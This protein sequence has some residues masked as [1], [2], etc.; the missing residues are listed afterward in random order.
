MS[1]S[2]GQSEGIDLAAVRA[3]T[4]GV[5]EVVHL[6]NAGAALPPTPVVQAVQAHI[7]LEARIGGYE[8]EERRHAQ[9]DRVYGAAAELLHCEPEEIAFIE[10]ATWAWGHGVL[11]V[12]ARAR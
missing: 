4:P 2:A 10:N 8:A 1:A 6:N 3:D 5:K 12:R 7:A 9:V 11:L